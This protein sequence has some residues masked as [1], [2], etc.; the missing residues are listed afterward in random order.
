MR[1]LILSDLHI[2]NDGPQG[3]YAGGDAL[4]KL[5]EREAR[6]A[7]RIILNGD[8]FDF[9]PGDDPLELDVGRAV[10]KAGQ[11]VKVPVAAATLR[12]PSCTSRPTARW[13]VIRRSTW[14]QG[15]AAPPGR[16][17][18]RPAV[19]RGRRQ[20]PRRS[21]AWLRCLSPGQAAR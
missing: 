7:V 15:T 3:L 6:G 13:P 10:A 12:A 20:R 4:P 5:L 2:S 19:A 1:T 18:G 16:P 8:A 11:I 14:V 17:P 21:A 9:L